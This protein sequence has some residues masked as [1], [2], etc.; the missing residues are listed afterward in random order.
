[1][2]PL[3]SA[4]AQPVDAL[5]V[6]EMATGRILRWN[7]AAERLFGYTA[8]EAIGRPIETLLYTSIEQLHDQRVAHYVRTGKPDVLT[9]REPLVV[10][11]R[12]RS[13]ALLRVE[14]LLAYLEVPGT[15]TWHDLL[16]FRRA[17]RQPRRRA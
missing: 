5:V 15:P 3:I 17:D 16:T 12:G 13:G 14:V 9:G 8:S 6:C 11:A 2:L 7:P 1:M 10:L 4:D